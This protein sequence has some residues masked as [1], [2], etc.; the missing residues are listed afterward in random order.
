M[1]G[2][3]LTPDGALSRTRKTSKCLRNES[4]EVCGPWPQVDILISMQRRDFE[5]LAVSLDSWRLQ[6]VRHWSLVCLAACTPWL[7]SPRRAASGKSPCLLERSWEDPRRA[8]GPLRSAQALLRKLARPRRKL[9]ACS[10]HAFCAGFQ[11]QAASGSPLP[12]GKAGFAWPQAAFLLGGRG[13]HAPL[14]DPIVWT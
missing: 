9:F 11:W 5:L 1:P 6:A 8:L 3:S 13:W 4:R 2:F 12:I 14:G 7:D 10:S